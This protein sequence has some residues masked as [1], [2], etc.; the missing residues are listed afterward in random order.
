MPYR[1]STLNRGGL[2]GAGLTLICLAVLWLAGQAVAAPPM[3]EPPGLF[4]DAGVEQPRDL[5][6][7]GRSR[8]VKL[9]LAQFGGEGADGSLQG[10]AAPSPTLRLNLFEDVI[11]T[12]TLERL[13]PNP[14]GGFIWIGRLPE[15]ELSQVLFWVSAA[16]MRATSWL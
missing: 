2:I 15:V 10:L 16:S 9:D 3:E 4:R 5:Q 12:A 11:L 6:V 7:R 1:K 14:S 13:E 8:L